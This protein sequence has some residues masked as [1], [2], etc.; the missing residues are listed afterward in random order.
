MIISGNKSKKYIYK[1]FHSTA[2]I[3]RNIIYTN[4]KD[5][6]T[7]PAGTQ[8]MKNTL[9]RGEGSAAQG[10]QIPFASHD[11][12]QQRAWGVPGQPC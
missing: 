7:S 9:F 4:K 3:N 12:G 1:K 2:T 10:S 5:G 6:R 8:L 11:E